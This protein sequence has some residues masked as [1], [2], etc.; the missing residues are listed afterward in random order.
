MDRL[1][2]CRSRVLKS[3]M[4]WAA[5]CSVSYVPVGS[6]SSFSAPICRYTRWTAFSTLAADFP[7]ELC[8]ITT[9]HMRSTLKSSSQRLSTLHLSMTLIESS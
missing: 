8:C 7:N 2:F 6:G 5:A 9:W 4:V 3:S 1:K